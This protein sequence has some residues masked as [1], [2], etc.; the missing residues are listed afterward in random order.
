MA[1]HSVPKYLK[2]KTALKTMFDLL[3][4]VPLIDVNSVKGIVLVC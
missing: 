2:A 3:R 1:G 4:R